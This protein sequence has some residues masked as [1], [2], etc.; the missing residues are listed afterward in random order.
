M[1][2]LKKALCFSVCSIVLMGV[3]LQA[4][5]QLVWEST[6]WSS[7]HPFTETHV[8]VDFKYQ[9][10]GDY[11]I[12]IKQLIGD[13]RGVKPSKARRLV[14]PG[15]TG[16]ATFWVDTKRLFRGESYSVGVKTSDR[17]AR[18]QLLSIAVAP[19]GWLEMDEDQRAQYT[20]M[21]EEILANEPVPVVFSKRVA[22]ANDLNAKNNTVA[23]IAEAAEGVRFRL[24]LKEEDPRE[25]AGQ[26]VRR[27]RAVTASVVESDPGK[28][29]QIVL[30]PVADGQ[31]S[32][33]PQKI[34]LSI[35]LP[36]RQLR[37]QYMEG[38][39]HVVWGGDPVA[40]MTGQPD[41]RVPDAPAVAPDTRG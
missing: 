16:A 39:M 22:S 10:T 34:D 4:H 1:F 38:G 20:E 41:L 15:Q 21:C 5:A 29:C 32:V 2:D 17:S 14:K 11:P 33:Y 13:D 26:A 28:L 23:I 12:R 3:P 30:R 6:S 27:P 18:S 35:D 37:R 31:A 25:V 40:R 36:E 8:R 19:E 24:T 9:N 7:E